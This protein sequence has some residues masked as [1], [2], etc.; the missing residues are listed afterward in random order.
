MRRKPASDQID[1][2]RRIFAKAKAK[3]FRKQH[4]AAEEF[5]WSHIRKRQLD[6]LKFRDQQ[7][8][9]GRVIDF[10]G[11]EIRLGIEVDGAAHDERQE[12]DAARQAF[13]EGLGIKIIR[14]SNDEVLRHIEKVLERIRKEA[15]AR[16]HFRY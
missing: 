12:E 2:E 15:D 8:V 13:I 10:Y 1:A 6:R 14:F 16:H 7:A 11:P 9:E 3:E 4:T 5:L